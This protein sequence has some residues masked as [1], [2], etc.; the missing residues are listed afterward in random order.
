MTTEIVL[1]FCIHCSVLISV[2]LTDYSPNYEG[3]FAYFL[4]EVGNVMHVSACLVNSFLYVEK[5]L[6]IIRTD[7]KIKEMGEVIT[8]AIIPGVRII[9]LIANEHLS[10]HE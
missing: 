1:V 6:P 2:H 5:F 7:D 10:M 4:L 3:C 9:S 8:S